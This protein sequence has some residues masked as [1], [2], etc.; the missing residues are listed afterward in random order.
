MRR[1][2]AVLALGVSAPALA[3]SAGPAQTQLDDLAGKLGYRFTIIDNNPVDC[4]GNAGGCFIS[5]I[6]ITTPAELPRALAT[7]PIELRYSYVARVLSAESD[8][9][10]NRLINGDLNALSLK[11]GKTLRPATTYRIRLTGTGHFFST[12]YPM[13]NAHLMLPGLQGRVI[14]AS[15]PAIDPETG[16]EYLPFVAPMTDEAEL[17]TAAP[18]DRTRWRTPERAFAINTERGVGGEPAHAILPAPRSV[19]PG[20]GAPVDLTRGVDLRLTGLTREAVAPALD[21][22]ALGT[23]NVPLTIGI[24]RALGA[25]GYRLTVKDNAVAIVAGDAAGASHALRSLAQQAAYTKG[26]VAPM[27]VE[28]A[29]RFGFRGL[30][31]DFARNFHSKALLLKLIEQMAVFKLNTLHLHLGDDEGWRMEIKALP[32]LTEI[33]AFRCFDAS[34]TRC[35]QPQLGADPDPEAPVNGFLSQAD[36]LE[37]L[38]AAKARHI[39]VIPSFDMPGHSRAAI[40][41]MEVRHERLTAAGKPAEAARYRLVEPADTTEY[42]SIQNYDD[43]TLNVCIDST[44]RFLDTMIDEVAALHR[45]AGL[46][47]KT[48]HIGADETAGAWGES[49]ACK[50]MMAKTGLKPAELGAH[51]IERVSND[52]AKK[53][54][55][56]AGW[57]DGMGHTKPENMPKGVQTNIWGGLFGGGVAEAHNQANRGWKTVISIPDIAYLDM[58][59]APHPMERGYDW[60]AREVEPFETFAFMPE[61]LPANAAVALDIKARP[62]K[63]ADSAPLQPG[64][65]MAGMQAQLWSETIRSDDQVEYMFF[66]RLMALAERAWHR[67]DWEPPYVAGATYAHGDARV[68]R[69]AILA[70]WRDF[71]AR[72]AAQLPALDK[73]DIAYRLAPPGARIADGRL[74]ANTE[75]P[76]IAIEYRVGEGAWQRY[77]APVAVSGP[78]TLRTRSPDGKRASRSVKVEP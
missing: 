17:A 44:Y 73:A 40:R 15:R 71:T 35:L 60:A 24:D 20:D 75:L 62:G 77:T 18:D 46:P 48:Y 31:I 56:A 25:E 32:E 43:N 58:P 1:L 26:R 19:K 51:F 4:P 36:Y 57:S 23:G 14:A 9:F 37:L 30:H 27:T 8:T 61:N 21:A 10:E 72:A 39:E 66:P 12:Y 33:G 3:Q 49:P 78:V 70:D 45:Q 13:P 65:G 54:I 68:D 67:A 63:L 69:A 42:R 22:L 11:P 5:E 64:R 41:A 52:L 76:G 74:E 38:A 53:G 6:A 47:L 28:D 29:P 16:L 7:A 2:I 34:E 50:A 59:Y 55:A